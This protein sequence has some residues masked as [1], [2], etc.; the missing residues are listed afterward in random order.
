MTFFTPGSLKLLFI[1]VS[2]KTE[3]KVNKNSKFELYLYSSHPI[4]D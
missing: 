2:K 4:L 1:N 3:T